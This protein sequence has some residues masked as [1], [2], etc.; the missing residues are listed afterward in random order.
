[1]RKLLGIFLSFSLIMTMFSTTAYA[2]ENA[3]PNENNYLSEE[4]ENNS[5]SDFVESKSVDD[6]QAQK[7]VEK[8]ENLMQEENANHAVEKEIMNSVTKKEK[9]VTY[10]A[11]IGETFYATLKEALMVGGE[12]TLLKDVSVNEIIEITQD[13]TLDLGDFTITDNAAK[14]PFVVRAENFTIK[15]N[16]GGMVIPESNNQAYGFVEAYVNNFSILGGKYQGNTDN[17]RLFRINTPES[18]TGTINVDGIVVNTNNEIIGHNGTFTNYSGSIRNS[19]FYTGMRSMY[20][21]IIDTAETST[22]TIDN[23]KAVIARGPVIEVA[24]GNTVL[25]NNDWTVTGNYEGGYTWAR[26]AVGVGYGANVTIKSG[27]YHAD[28][29]FMKENEGYGVYI[30][31][32]G[33]TVNIEEGSFSGTT[34][35]LRADVDKGTYN[36]PANIIVNNGEFNGDLLAK[37]NTGIES[38]VVNGGNFSGLTDATLN[39]TNNVQV[40]GGAFDLDVTNKVVEVKESIAVT[41]NNDTNYYIGKEKVKEALDHVMKGDKIAIIQNVTEIQVPDGVTVENK[42]GNDITV[43]GDVVK[44]NATIVVDEVPTAKVVYSHEGNWTNEDV[45]VT[46]TTS[47]PIED[48]RGWT[49]VDEQT[50]TKVYADNTLEN[51]TITDMTGNSNK[52]KVDVKNIDKQAP[53]IRGVKDISLVQG[54]NFD[55]LEGVS[56]YD[57]ECGAIKDIRVTVNGQPS[58]DTNVVGIYELQYS[59]SDMA[60]NTTTVK[61]IVTVNPK[62]ETLNHAPIIKA[63]DITL[64]VGDKF[65]PRKYVAAIDNEDG[66]LT[67][68]IEILENTVN[69]SKPGTYQVTYKVTDKEG[70][71]SRKVI[72]VVVNAKKE[73]IP[74]TPEKPNANKPSNDKGRVETGDQTNVGLYSS[75]FAISVLCIT[76]L[77]VWKKKNALENK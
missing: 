48:I 50:F 65:D 42:T 3:V 34:A 52:I 58:V 38:I 20:F 31:T 5:Q 13:T 1:M 6:E 28:S 72:K 71:S 61:R 15:A 51:I 33:G 64:T 25:S 60:G 9:E 55:P 56:A 37:T 35:A 63:D 10:E 11:K 39:N 16:N 67:E 54:S 7:N 76:I 30:Y 21:D 29:E 46:I 59:V 41:K 19:E 14:R 68:I 44:D 77:A 12:V 40:N 17:G 75:L 49:K 43:N 62:E 24:G 69:T 8:T 4:L 2:E 66:N 47:E 57:Y 27:K 70:A 36:T 74:S 18:K 22:I 73:I 32:S 45:T 23:T 53:E 26:T